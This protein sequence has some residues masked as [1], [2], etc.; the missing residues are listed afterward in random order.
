MEKMKYTSPA[1]EIADVELEQGIAASSATLSGGSNGTPDLP[2]AD[3]WGAEELGGS[4]SGD[5]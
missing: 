2:A 1:I 3:G 5:F 4:T